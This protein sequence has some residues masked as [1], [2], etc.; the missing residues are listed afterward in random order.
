VIAEQVLLWKDAKEEEARL[1]AAE[2]K[3]KIRGRSRVF[4]WL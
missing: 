2:T 4:F 1:A 3:N